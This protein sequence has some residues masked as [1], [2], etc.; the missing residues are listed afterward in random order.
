M[1]IIDWRIYRLNYNDFI[2]EVKKEKIKELYFFSGEEIYLMDKALEELIKSVL[3][4]DL[5]S[6][7]LSYLDGKISDLDSLKLSCETLPFLSPKRITVLN[8]PDFMEDLVKNQDEAIAYLKTLGEHQALIIID[9]KSS[10]KKSTKLYKYIKGKNCNVNFEKLKGIELNNW[11]VEKFKLNGKIIAN[12][13][14]SYFL[15][16][17]SYLSRNIDSTLYDLENEIKKLSAYSERKEITNEDM[18]KALVKNIDRNI[19]DLLEA[20]S[21]KDSDKTI[22]IF[23]EIYAMNEPIQKIIFM[24]ARQFRLL[25]AIKLYA[26][27]GYTSNEIQLKLGLKPYEFSKLIKQV[28]S[29]SQK[30]LNQVLEDILETD[31]NMKTRSCDQKLEMELLLVKLADKKVV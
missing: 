5:Q 12:S 22:S 25:N 15:R 1:N 23:N 18:D 24:I 9:R 20:V 29:F 8:N 3:T 27:V 19:F 11:I 10:I 21:K 30:T 7:N 13:N 2:S 31:K 4:E 6:I 26:I 16:A 14:I 17:S 28:G